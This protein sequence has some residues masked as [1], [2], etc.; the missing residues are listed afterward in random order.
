MSEQVSM[1]DTWDILNDIGHK[2]TEVTA[3]ILQCVRVLVIFSLEQLPGQINILKQ[4]IVQRVALS[5]QPSTGSVKKKNKQ[6]RK[7]YDTRLK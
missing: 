6:Q 4:C 2:C 5:I 1:R 7:D 3:N